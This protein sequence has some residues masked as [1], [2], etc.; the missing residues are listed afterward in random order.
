LKPSKCS[1][2]KQEVKFL[3]RVVSAEG[4]AINPDTTEKSKLGLFHT[5]QKR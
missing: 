4:V 1:L 5:A 3:G 2:F